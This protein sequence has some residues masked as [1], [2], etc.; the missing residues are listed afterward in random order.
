MDGPHVA[1]I[2]A[3]QVPLDLAV[4][5]TDF[6]RGIPLAMFNEEDDCAVFWAICL[7]PSS[8]PTSR[9]LERLR[10]A[11]CVI[12]TDT[13]ELLREPR[14]THAKMV[15]RSPAHLSTVVSAILTVLAG[16]TLLERLKAHAHSTSPAGA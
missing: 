16:P 13:T 12:R 3:V 14:W 8:R 9:T 6:M 11:R 1:E 4:E 2:V 15:G 7:R 5:A 10:E